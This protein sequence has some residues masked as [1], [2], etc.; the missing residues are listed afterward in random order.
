MGKATNRRAAFKAFLAPGVTR[1]AATGPFRA[2]G[3]TRFDAMDL[4]T[5][6]MLAAAGMVAGAINSVAGGGS[7]I[8]FPALLATG[9]P[10]VLASATNTVA[11]APGS[12][13]AAW[14]YRTERGGSGRLAVFLT[15]PAVAGSLSGAAL[16]LALPAA[17]F[18]AVVPWLI[19]GAT[20]LILLKDL[21]SRKASETS[22]PASH[23]RTALVAVGVLLTAVY[24]GYF[25]AGMGIILLA[26]LALLHRMNI[27]EMN[28]MKTIIVGAINGLSALYFLVL[29]AY[30]G[31][32]AAVMA[33]GS[34]IGG[35][36]G[37]TVAKAINPTIVRGV[38]VVIGVSLSAILAYRKWFADGA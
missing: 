36:G 11:M 33:V 2:R 27:H 35:W 10:Q 4:A 28:A 5:V 29:G 25:G 7:L 30:E 21:I 16:L 19:L 23:T 6:L 20:S 14:A 26:M 31:K 8:A 15:I 37:A 1:R 12:L 9:L 17:V 13:S 24:G 18:E 38:V 3:V 22:G 34:L 32:A